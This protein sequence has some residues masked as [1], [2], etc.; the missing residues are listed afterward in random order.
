MKMKEYKVMG[1]TMTATFT[2]GRYVAYSP[3]EA[4]NMARENYR[5]SSLGRAMKDAGAFRFY[6]VEK[7]PNES[8]TNG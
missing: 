6:V 2:A 1:S 7:F 8:D 4:C 3:S 5:D